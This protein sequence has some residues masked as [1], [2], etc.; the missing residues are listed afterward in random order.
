MY[1][2]TV[3][4]RGEWRKAIEK[5]E[6]DEEEAAERCEQCFVLKQLN[7]DALDTVGAAV[8]FAVP[9]GSGG[10]ER[11]GSY[12]NSKNLVSIGVVPCH[13]RRSAT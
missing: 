7:H 10:V 13:T 5:K 6:K 2:G 11:R 4:Q 9:G 3:K 1:E 12:F 8:V